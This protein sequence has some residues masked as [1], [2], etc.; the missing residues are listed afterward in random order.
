MNFEGRVKGGLP[1]ERN[2]HP[3][4]TSGELDNR[5]GTP[6]PSEPDEA[7]NQPAT[8]SLVLGIVAFVIQLMAWGLTFVEEIEHDAAFERWVRTGLGDP[9]QS[10]S[11]VAGVTFASIVSLAV[12][13]GAIVS[14]VRGRRVAEADDVGRT[15]ANIGLALGIVCVGIPILVLLAFIAYVSCCID[16]L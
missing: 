7:W 2:T 3:S 6:S 9:P 5:V 4:D 1:M 10:S 14:G 13:I 15:R 16:T 11:D 12:G 8:T